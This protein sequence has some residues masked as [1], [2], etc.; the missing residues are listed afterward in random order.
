MRLAHLLLDFRDSY[1]EAA[2]KRSTPLNHAAPE[3]FMKVIK[4]IY[5]ADPTFKKG[6]IQAKAL[7]E[8]FSK[9]EK[10]VKKSEE[11][12]AS[13]TRDPFPLITTEK[14]DT[15]DGPSYKAPL[16][17]MATGNCV[18]ERYASA[19]LSRLGQMLLR[20][21]DPKEFGF[22]DSHR[23]FKSFV[24]Y[25]LLSFCQPFT[26]GM[27][28]NIVPLNPEELFKI[29]IEML[30]RGTYKLDDDFIRSVFKGFDVGEDYT[31]LMT[32]SAV[33]DLYTGG[34][35]SYA[36]VPKFDIEITDKCI[37]FR[38]PPLRKTSVKFKETLISANKSKNGNV[39]DTFKFNNDL[40]IVSSGLKLNVTE[41]KTTDIA[42]ITKDIENN[43]L[44]R[45]K[46]KSIFSTMLL[47]DKREILERSRESQGEQQDIGEKTED[48]TAQIVQDMLDE[49]DF[50]L[51]Q[52]KPM[53]FSVDIM[54]VYEELWNCLLIERQAKIDEINKEIEALKATLDI[55]KLLER[56][57]R[58]GV[59]KVI[60]DLNT[61][62]RMSARM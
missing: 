10:M 32:N 5:M 2:M 23:R 41:F 34:Y 35:A 44:V 22:I 43:A 46:G 39:F 53:N 27:K 21:E 48:I 11:I 31:V 20:H 4:A 37:I 33:R 47:K 54:P 30:N 12:L 57:T 25:A 56:I 55:E 26:T 42:S 24:P 60:N 29:Q 14:K 16:Y 52:E 40:E 18:A 8:Y 7:G 49:T 45:F 59:N 13:L 51:G 61:K 28:S 58:P 3:N 38:V 50:K 15:N 9:S 17:N 6:V 19:C 1:T 62:G 36:V